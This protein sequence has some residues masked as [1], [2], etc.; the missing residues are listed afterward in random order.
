MSFKVVSSLEE[1]FIPSRSSTR[2]LS[3]SSDY[4]PL[5]SLTGTGQ[6]QGLCSAKLGQLLQPSPFTP[7]KCTLSLTD[8]GL[9]HTQSSL[10]AGEMFGTLI[11]STWKH[12]L[13]KGGVI[14]TE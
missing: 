11:L 4:S 13:D 5:P 9:H 12:A 7:P 14:N 6:P 10:K 3:L 2:Q 1:L 8:C